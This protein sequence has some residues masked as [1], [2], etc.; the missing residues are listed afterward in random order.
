[1]IVNRFKVFLLFFMMLIADSTLAGKI[2]SCGFS[3]KVGAHGASEASFLLFFEHGVLDGINLSSSEASGKEGGA[4]FCNLEIDKSTPET[5]WET[6]GNTSKV[7]IANEYQ[8]G[9][10][11]NIEVTTHG[12]STVVLID[13]SPMPYCGFGAAFPSK[14]TKTAIGRCRVKF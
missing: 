11:P 14:M 4:Y 6:V 8:D 10:E 3:Q 13:L 7:W 12:K 9:D 1:M 5:R 2:I